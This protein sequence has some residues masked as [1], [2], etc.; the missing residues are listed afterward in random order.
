VPFGCQFTKRD[1]ANGEARACGNL[2]PA[3]LPRAGAGLAQLVE[4]R[5]C[6]PKVGGSS[7]STGTNL[8]NDLPDILDIPPDK[9]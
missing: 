1:G 8:F 4:Q 5:F 3:L 7:P 6:K 9:K 2:G